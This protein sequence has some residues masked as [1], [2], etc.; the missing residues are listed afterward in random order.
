MNRPIIIAIDGPGASGKGTLARRLA[1]HLGYA[2]LDT[3][4]MYRAVA[5]QMLRAGKDL[6][7]AQAA[8]I[9]AQNLDT[10]LID[11][12]QLR[13]DTVT[14]AA[15][16]VAAFGDVRQAL[17]VFQR[18]FA[19]NPP[20]NAPGAVLDGRDIGTV[21]CPDAR[22]K[23]F[24]TASQEARAHRR[25]LELGARGEAANEAS[26]LADLQVRDA[27]DQTRAVAPLRPAAD[28]V[29]LDTTNMAI[30]DAFAAA[31]AII[32]GKIASVKKTH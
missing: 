19:T 16:R 32:A 1:A 11:D 4:A 29:L 23:L 2:Y 22:V 14:D 31:L 6:S 20:G 3:G 10:S 18:S 15:S 13:T 25:Y 27:R 12:P 24:V 5:L 8:L 7:D 17:M 30:D 28:A 26:I 21:I 9:A